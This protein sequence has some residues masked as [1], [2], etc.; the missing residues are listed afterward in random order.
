M[1][2]REKG[3]R[4]RMRRLVVAAATSAALLLASCG[5]P[6]AEGEGSGA[7][8][9]RLYGTDG[10]MQD[11]FG[12]TLANRAVLRGMKGTAPLNPLPAEFTNRLLAIDSSLEGF[13]FAGE[14]YDAVVISAL[15]AELAGTPDPAVVRNY[16]NSVTAGGTSC[17]TVAD[18]LE[19]ARDGEDLAYEGVSLRGRGFTDRG[20]PAAASYATMHFGRN[21][22]IDDDKT[23]FVGAG[24]PTQVTQEPPPAPSPRD[25]DPPEP[26]TLGGLL[27]ETGDLSFAYPPLMAGAQLALQEINDAGGVFGEDIEWVDGDDGTNPDVARETLASH[28]EDG[29]H[30][31]IG[32]AAS[33]V[34]E[35]VLPD[36][37]AAG[38]ILFSPSNT[39]AGL[40]SVDSDGFYFRTAPSDL[41]QGAALAD[42][43]LRDGVERV[44]IV[45]RDDAYGRGL[46]ENARDSLR[47]FGVPGADIQLLTY[48]VP[49]SED[50]PVPGLDGLVG[51]L[52]SAEPDGVVLVG[53]S[54]AAHVIQAM[55]EAGL[56]SDA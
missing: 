21:G 32:A 42:I 27:P 26:L 45:A 30:I 41:L 34:T 31:V 50:D 38:R 9:V 40:S 11:A 36:A 52:V 10:T 33:G 56:L 3:P 7:G 17:S 44:A 24:D 22:F 46:Q 49:E 5:D 6:D 15:A 19:L 43:I 47:R 4:M 14:T 48:A 25:E 55:V 51:D 23:E 54:E 53:F 20:E 16:I 39:A 13:L 2:V 1:E 37:V 8:T 18:C 28:A 12:A 29:V 35:A